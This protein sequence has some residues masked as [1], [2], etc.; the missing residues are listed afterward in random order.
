MPRRY[1][2]YVVIISVVAL[3]LLLVFNFIGFNSEYYK[4][5]KEYKDLYEETVDFI[6]LDNISESIQ[7]N[8]LEYNVQQ[9]NELL[10]NMN[11]NI[12]RIKIKEYVL[13]V[14]RQEVLED[15][16]DKGLKYETLSDLDKYLVKEGVAALKPKP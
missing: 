12:P 5:S 13:L 2:Y 15:T 3:F 7:G 8:N 10:N 16:V 1:Y 11:S 14:M 4:L 9:L 6:D